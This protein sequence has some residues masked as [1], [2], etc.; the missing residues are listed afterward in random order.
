[1][2]LTK[3]QKIGIVGIALLAGVALGLGTVGVVRAQHGASARPQ[4]PHPAVAAPVS[5]SPTSTT[6]VV[7]ASAAPTPAPAP[8]PAPGG[9]QPPVKVNPPL[10]LNPSLIDAIDVAGPKVQITKVACS[11]GMTI[12]FTAKDESGIASVVAS[13]HSGVNGN[14]NSTISAIISSPMPDL[15]SAFFG[16]QLFMTYNQLVITATDSHGNSTTTGLTDVCI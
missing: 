9:N 14:A 7:A 11:V 15:Y 6:V 3:Y 1:M 5:A 10:P 4:V 16:K 13:L 12:S 2:S 8:A